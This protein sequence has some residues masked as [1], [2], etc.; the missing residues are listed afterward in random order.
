MTLRS[1]IV[2]FTGISDLSYPKVPIMSLSSSSSSKSSSCG[3][4]GINARGTFTREED[5]LYPSSSSVSIYE[6]RDGTKVSTTTN[7]HGYNYH[8]Q[9]QQDHVDK[10]HPIKNKEKK[11]KKKSATT[12]TINNNIDNDISLQELQAE[13]VADLVRHYELE[14]L[15]ETVANDP[16]ETTGRVYRY[17]CKGNSSLPILY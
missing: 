8:Q 9:Q 17:T 10:K 14:N 13:R 7:P 3:V 11:K 16:N 1:D 12:T 2:I 15:P 4:Q 5:A 6:T